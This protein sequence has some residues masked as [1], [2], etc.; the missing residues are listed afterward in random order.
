MI[1]PANSVIGMVE[2]QNIV[3]R[4]SAHI[5]Q[6]FKASLDPLLVFHNYIH[7]RDVVEM[8]RKIGKGMKLDD[9]SLE[10]VTIAAWFHDTGY[11]EIYQGHERKSADMAAA[12][13]LDHGYPQDKL[14]KVIGCILATQVPQKPKNLIEEVICDADLSHF[15]H[16]SF[17][18]K[19]DLL[20]IEWDL[21]TGRKFTD[22]EW[23]NHTLGF[24]VQTS[25][26]TKYAQ[27]EFNNARVENLIRLQRMRTRLEEEAKETVAKEER[28]IRRQEQEELDAAAQ[29]ERRRRREEEETK[30]ESTKR[31]AKR[32]KQELEEQERKTKLALAEEKVVGKAIKEKTP[33]R[34]IETMFRVVSKNQMELSAMADNKANIMISINALIVGVVL[35]NLISKLDDNPYLTIPALLILVVCLSTIIVATIA[36]RPKV[37]SGMFT[38]EQV[39]EKKVNLLFFGNFYNMKLPDYEEGMNAMLNDREYLYGSMIKDNYFLGQVLGRKYKYLRLSYNIFMYG[40]VVA[41]IVFAAAFLIFAA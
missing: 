3:K 41:V 12:F 27:L 35:T 36:T 32:R 34:G 2:K 38:R 13:L 19:S 30:E 29:A 8:S 16:E 15:G 4:T 31:E 5:F 25:Y 23:A 1:D 18:E 10:I 40:L 39:Q 20:R 11:T 14:D 6:L 28:R 22:L 33:E 21:K 37:T 24:F 26:F 7:T 17:F 9:E